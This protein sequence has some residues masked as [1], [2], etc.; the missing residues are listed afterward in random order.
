MELEKAGF[1]VYQALN[2]EDA[3]KKISEDIPDLVILDIQ[4]PVM[5]GWEVC[6]KI[7]GRTAIQHLPIMIVSSYNQPEDIER[8]KL[9]HVKRHL[10]KPCPAKVVIRNVRDILSQK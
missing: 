6:A 10:L 4:M 1:H 8:G 9:F 7:R 2:G 5:D 3:V